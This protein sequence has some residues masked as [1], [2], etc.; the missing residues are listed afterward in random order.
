MRK[1]GGGPT[2][3]AGKASATG[4]QSPHFHLISQY[5]QG[6]IS[7]RMQADVRLLRL[8]CTCRHMPPLVRKI[9]QR[10]LEKLHRPAL[11]VADPPVD[12]QER[13][14]DIKK[15]FN[16]HE[17]ATG[18][19]VLGLYGMGGIGKT[20]LAKAVFNDLH[21]TFSSSSCFL[22]VGRDAA[23]NRLQQLQHQALK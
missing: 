13:V 8:E 7:S 10:V 22:E 19:A 20:T 15:K 5:A 12:V 4:E 16:K 11:H 2:K 14:E 6:L 17:L 9:V 3:P 1:Q 18:K 23:D 21:P